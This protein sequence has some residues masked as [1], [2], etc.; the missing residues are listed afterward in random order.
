MTD[1]AE[2]YEGD[3]L[4]AGFDRGVAFV[5]Y[6]LLIVSPFL[7]GAPAVVAFVLALA[8]RNDSHWLIRSHYRNQS[9]IFGVG[10]T[11]LVL[12]ILC[13]LGASGLALDQ[14]GNFVIEQG[15]NA[16]LIAPPAVTDPH[17]PVIVHKGVWTAGLF[18]AGLVSLCACGLY[19]FV[20]SIVGLLRLLGNRPIARFTT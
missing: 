8:H 17:P 6:G 1:G 3:P 15:R 4:M 5:G 16:G 10:L 11:L 18:V 2:H 13:A 12:A 9:H 19:T 7:F 20:A 14:L